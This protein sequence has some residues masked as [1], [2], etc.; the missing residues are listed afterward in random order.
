VE[1]RL[2][3]KYLYSF[4]AGGVFTRPLVAELFGGLDGEA[5][6]FVDDVIL[7]HVLVYNSKIKWIILT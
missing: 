5:Y 4:V 3:H 1:H 6:V 2:Q 7:I